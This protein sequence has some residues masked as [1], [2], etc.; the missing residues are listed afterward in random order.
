[1]RQ[2]QDKPI[3]NKITT[4]Q[5]SR[6]MYEIV[7]RQAVSLDTSSKMLNLLSID[8][9][10]RINNRINKD[11]NMFNT[12]RGFFSQSL[13]DNVYYAAKAG[14]TSESRGET[15]YIATSDRKTEYILTIFAEDPGYAYNWDIFPEISHLVFNDMKARN[16]ITS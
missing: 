16:N 13:P 9:T 7:N 5:T 12:V 3:R 6:L 2:N 4:K 10:T 8:A 15:A 11:P 14:W 1:M